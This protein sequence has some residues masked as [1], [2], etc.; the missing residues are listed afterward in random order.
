MADP[1]AP[2]I[3][4][5]TVD[6]VGSR[7]LFSGYSVSRR[8]RPYAAGLMGC[9]TL[10]MLDEA[11]ISRPFER[12]LRTIE[13]GR[14]ARRP[15]SDDAIC[16]DFAGPA[17][18]PMLPPPFYVLPLTATSGGTSESKPFRLGAEDR[19][20]EIIRARLY[21]AKTLTIEEL[22]GNEKLEDM[23]AERAW[24]LA[25]KETASIGARPRIL[26]Y[27]DWRTV[28]EK[29]EK[30]LRKRIRETK[31]EA[32]TILF[33]G[34]RR[35][36]ERE[37]AA[38]E[39]KKYGLI[40]D[41]EGKPSCIIFLVATAAGEVGVDLDADHMVCDLVA[42]ERMVQRLGRV[43]RRG[44]GAAR[45]LVI[46]EGP[47]KGK[48]S[49]KN[50]TARHEAVRKLLE[51]LPAAE[52]VG[53]QASPAALD[54]LQRE[55]VGDL[56]KKASTPMPLYP[57]LSRALVDAWSM[58]S[59][60]EHT[61]RPEVQPW[62]RGWVEDEPQTTVVWR[63]C[64]PLRF[65]KGDSHALTKTPKS[66]V[67]AFFDAAPLQMEELLE[68]E[69]R[70]VVDWLKKRTRKLLRSWREGTED[71]ISASE[72]EGFGLLRPLRH[73][74]PVAYLLNNDGTLRDAFSLMS[75]DGLQLKELSRKLAGRRLVVDARFGGIGN[76]LLDD[77]RGEVAHT[78]EDNDWSGG[79]KRKPSTI[80]V[81]PVRGDDSV[82]HAWQKTFEMP[83]LVSPDGDA[84]VL[85]V[86]EK[87]FDVQTDEEA[88]AVAPNMQSLVEHQKWVA[89]KAANIA[90][91]LALPK[92][93]RAMLVAAALQHDE[94]KKAPRWQR[95]FSAPR[96]NVLYA[97]TTRPPNRHVLNG[98]RHEFGSVLNAQSCGFEGV[99]RTDLRFELALH[100]IAAHH[101][102]ARPTIETKGCDSHPPAVAAQE[103]REIALRFA[104]LQRQ[105]GPWGLAWWEALLRAADQQAS[106]RL[107][108][109]SVQD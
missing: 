62:L 27:C 65:E 107:S 68:T 99:D 53:Y 37:E 89:D 74:V 87:W 44:A 72:S 15:N 35:V 63:R 59:L 80:R 25:S 19:E 66:E 109:R 28:A 7:L 24:R 3:I 2:A 13:N 93:D 18:S 95:A 42:W 43:N 104:R 78:I 88:R 91:A 12:L 21:A 58:T 108:E 34:G 32:E 6:M 38:E 48:N 67:E 79:P 16:G 5:G 96:G 23:L 85:L 90:E 10:V 92:D 94:G 20:N 83:Y 50:K 98:Y 106:R 39:L 105:W 86:V 70:Q 82:S 36:Y 57:A 84:D 40:A 77:S 55:T 75:L 17:V 46:D 49:D 30:I 73:D 54:R 14:S 4:V 97:K 61:G 51:C 60:L 22:Q 71:D 103:A 9:D 100:L 64:L 52:T 47:S 31:T 29:V 69:T 26:I 56:I 76:G 102:N 11:H 41:S 101:G 1:A 33:V 8:M 81:R 45:V